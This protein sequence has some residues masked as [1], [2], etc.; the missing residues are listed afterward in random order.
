MYPICYL[1][2]WSPGE[3]NFFHLNFR[4]SLQ[5]KVQ[6]APVQIAKNTSFKSKVSQSVCCSVSSLNQEKRMNA[7]HGSIQ[8]IE[9]FTNVCYTV[10]ILL[11]EQPEATEQGVFVF[12][13]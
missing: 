10:Y 1:I 2:K 6:I 7:F 3:I 11:K 5:D 8:Q 12:L 13:L 9:N 4:F